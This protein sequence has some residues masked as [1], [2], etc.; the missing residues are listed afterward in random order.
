MSQTAC[1][2]FGVGSLV[3]GLTGIDCSLT[4]VQAS[5]LNNL[6]INK[7]RIFSFQVIVYLLS[8]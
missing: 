8:V 2:T 6:A 4:T 1:Y 3:T 5:L 7:L